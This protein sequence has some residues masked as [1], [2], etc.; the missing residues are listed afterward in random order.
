MF[1]ETLAQ[2]VKDK[3]QQTIELPEGWAQGRAFFGGFSAGIAADFIL[4][5]F[6]AAYHMRAFNVSFVAPTAP[7]KAELALNV[8]RQ[9]SSVVQVSAQ[10]IQNGEVTLFALASLGKAR[11]SAVFEGQEPAP[12][13]AAPEQGMGIPDSPVTPEFAKHFDYRIL[14]GGMPFSGQVEREFGGWVRFRN[15]HHEMTIAA[16]LGLVDAWPPAVLPRLKK[17]APASSLTWTI[18]FPDKR[19]SEKQT[20]AWWRYLATI[21]Y[22][23]DGYGHSRAGLWD[24]QGELFAISRQT[25]TVFA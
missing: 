25:F 16:V 14:R 20:T 18:E 10:I 4:K 9:G 22:A 21:E 24:E 23:A 7:G 11:E 8:L 3:H 19:L 17:P 5:Q 2:I 13:F 1:F 6:D 12:E 15:E